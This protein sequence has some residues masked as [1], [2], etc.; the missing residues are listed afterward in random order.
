[1]FPFFLASEARPNKNIFITVSKVLIKLIKME[2][3]L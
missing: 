1:M 3:Y 2:F